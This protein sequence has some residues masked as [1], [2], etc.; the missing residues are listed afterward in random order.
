MQS[1]LVVML[2]LNLANLDSCPSNL[3]RLKLYYIID[4]FAARKRVNNAKKHLC[5]S[6]WLILN[7]SVVV[8]LTYTALAIS[9]YR[10]AI[11]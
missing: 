1:Y 5:S 9:P 4:N 3:V 11:P 10:H 2:A 6:L 7:G 8:Q